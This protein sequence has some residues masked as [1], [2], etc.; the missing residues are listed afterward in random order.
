MGGEGM[1][2]LVTGARGFIG[3][4]LIAE[5]RNRGYGEIFPCDLDTDPA[6]L[7]QFCRE[8]DFVYHLAGVNRPEDPAEFMAG[9]FGFTSVLLDNLKKHRSKAPVLITSSIQA[10]LDN[11]YGQ[12]KKAGEDL[13]YA[14]G[15][16]SEVPVFVYRL[17]NVFGKWCRPNY[18]SAVATF[19]HNIARDLPITVRDPEAVVQLVYV[20]DV[21][22]EFIRRMGDWAGDGCGVQEPDDSE[23]RTQIN[24]GEGCQARELDDSECRAQ[25]DDGEECRARELDDGECRARINDGEECQVRERQADECGTQDDCLT[26]GQVRDCNACRTQWR[27]FEVNKALEGDGGR[28]QEPESD[29][30][31]CRMQEGEGDSG[32]RCA[33]EPDGNECR[34]HEVASSI[35]ESC[36]QEPQGGECCVQERELDRD[37]CQVQ[38]VYTVTLGEIVALLRSFRQSRVDLSIPDQSGPFS[39]KLYSTYLSY[40]PETDFA[41]DLKM[42]C[43]P[44]G[45]FTEFIRTPERGQVSVNVAKPGICKGNHWHHS[46]N[47][48]FL[49]VSGWGLIRFRPLNR[50]E[51]IEYPVSGDKLQVV[52]IPPGYTHNIENLGDTDL[53]TVMWASEPFDP[54]RPDTYYLEV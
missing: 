29:G 2:I 8:C 14:Y 43:D 31:A 4:N 25:I 49:V 19:C 35:G 6:D 26:P 45:S 34:V 22:A 33:Q 21:V 7:D 16:E 47:E 18:N 52:D 38:P 51:V 50:D 40:L 46:K 3:Q 27:H 5:L 32:A 24:D 23:C 36:A 17:A 12:S 48:K 11:P 28:G 20:D 9:N 30:H 42:N 41:Y 15:A 53:I 10:A 1:K 37:A 13:L 39:R 44:R 54:E